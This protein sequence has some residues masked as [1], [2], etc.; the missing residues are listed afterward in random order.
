MNLRK[1]RSKA[2]GMAN[3]LRTGRSGV[4]L[5]EKIRAETWSGAHSLGTVDFPGGNLTYVNVKL[6]PGLPWQKL[7]SSRRRLFLPANW[8]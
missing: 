7:H 8:T 5:L 1:S 2:V 4:C 6:N 3:K